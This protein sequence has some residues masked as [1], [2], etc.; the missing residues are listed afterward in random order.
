MALLI[1][2]KTL[3]VEVLLEVLPLHQGYILVIFVP[4]I[5]LQTVVDLVRQA[6]RYALLPLKLNKDVLLLGSLKQ[7]AD[8]G[9]AHQ[10]ASLVAV[11]VRQNDDVATVVW[12]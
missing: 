2:A 6:M 12:L 10:I 9:A 5:I 4:E 11:L 7:I 3:L 8:D 1:E